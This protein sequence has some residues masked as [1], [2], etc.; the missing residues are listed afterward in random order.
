MTGL[1]GTKAKRLVI[2]VACVVLGL[3]FAGCSGGSDTPVKKTSD[4]AA[5]SV[6]PGGP[7]PDGKPVNRGSGR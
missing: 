1:R 7:G 4:P 5:G 3:Q 6:P 2:A